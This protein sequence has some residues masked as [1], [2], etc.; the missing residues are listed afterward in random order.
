M[1]AAERAIEAVRNKY[2]NCTVE[3]ICEREGIEIRRREMGDDCDGFFVSGRGSPVIFVKNTL[4]YQQ[5]REVLA[6]E[7]GHHFER[8]LD[9]MLSD[10]AFRDNFLSYS[11][12][13]GESEAAVFAAL[14]LCHD[15]SDC[16]SYH[17]IMRKYDC[18]KELAKLRMKIEQSRIYGGLSH[19]FLEEER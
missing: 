14:L 9:S 12:R 11:C 16:E 6:H 3:E 5:M 13:K 15:L 1:R 18:S 7:L 10:R 19:G 17:D 4:N 2:P 8:V